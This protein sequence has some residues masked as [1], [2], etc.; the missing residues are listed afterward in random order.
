M[1]IPVQTA[2]PPIESYPF[3]LAPSA[4]HLRL[5]ARC[6]LGCTFCERESWRAGDKP[7]EPDMAPLVLDRALTAYLPHMAGLELA[8]LGEPTM[9]RDFPRAAAAAVDAGKQ[10]YFPTNGYFLGARRVIDAVGE[11]PRVSI[12]LDAWDEESYRRVRGGEWRRVQ[13]AVAR[14][15]AARPRAM[16]HS[17]F[18]AGTYNI[19]G[20]P[21]FMEVC[22]AWG[23]TEIIMRFVQCHTV[24]REDVSLR[25]ARDR[26]EAAIEAARA[27]AEREGLWFIA[28][29]RPYSEDAP[30]GLD[31]PQTPQDRMRR[32]LDFAPMAFGPF[33]IP[34]TTNCGG[35]GSGGS[36]VGTLTGGT[37]GGSHASGGLTST[38]VLCLA[39]GTPVATPGGHCAVQRLRPGDVVCSRT[40][41]GAYA[42]E[43]VQAVRIFSARPCLCVHHAHGTFTCSESHEVLGVRG[44]H[45]PVARMRACDLV[46]SDMLLSREGK[47]VPIRGITRVAP[48]PVVLLSLVG[49]N[50]TYMA[51]GV[52]HH[53]KT[54]QPFSLEIGDNGQPVILRSPFEDRAP[55]GQPIYQTEAALIV[56]ADGE[57]W[58]CFAR[59]VVGD[60]IHDDLA[61]VIARPRYQAFL[62]RR[63]WEREVLSEGWCRNCPRTY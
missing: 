45:G 23:I 19:D 9:S 20:L 50:H 44:E 46:V 39:P 32:Y 55:R 38:T 31:G 11:T 6:N 18:T 1:R 29:R 61:H 26:T 7:A 4:L 3:L 59:H 17:Q 47:H 48:R 16:L 53:N 37:G 15:R 34:A 43:E 56:A 36:G 60:I 2:D 8:G 62:Q 40:P 28:E 10:L 41:A 30:N 12:S 24:A 35:V 49:P 33:S 51:A 42:H 13:R 58:S 52:W 25:F 21:A 54:A 57:L 5:S 22:A 63:E 27:V 14:F